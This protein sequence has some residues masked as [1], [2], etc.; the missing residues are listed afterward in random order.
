MLSVME[1]LL[2]L[3]KIENLYRIQNV[4]NVVQFA[5]TRLIFE[6]RGGHKA[7]NIFQWENKVINFIC[8]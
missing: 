3:T 8:F 1:I 5:F 4:Y 7:M 2:K 6:G